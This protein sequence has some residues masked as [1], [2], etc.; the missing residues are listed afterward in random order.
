[1]GET[2]ESAWDVTGQLRKLA[3][4]L[5]RDGRTAEARSVFASIGAVEMMPTF[6][7]PGGA[8]G[9]A[10]EPAPTPDY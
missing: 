7:D 3:V 10:V 6:S 1:M 9:A 2:S 8:A 4:E 5:V